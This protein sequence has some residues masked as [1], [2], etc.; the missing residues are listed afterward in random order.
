MLSGFLSVL[1]ASV[2]ISASVSLSLPGCSSE[3][4]VLSL[5]GLL[6]VVSLLDVSGSFSGVLTVGVCSETLLAVLSVSV[7]LFSLTVALLVVLCEV[8]PDGFDG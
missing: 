2:S 5:S 4:C 6:L 3:L 1:S 8:L 7:V